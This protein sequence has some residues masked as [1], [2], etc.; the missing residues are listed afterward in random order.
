M[1]D[2]ILTL[3]HGSDHIL[4]KPLFGFGKSDNDYGSGFYTTLSKEKAAEWAAANGTDSAYINTYEIDTVGLNVINLDKYG[5]LSWASEIIYNRG[6][7]GEA[8]ILLGNELVKQYKININD[9]DIVVGYRAD[10]SYSDIVDAFLQNQLNID[11]VQRLF[12]KGELGLQYF[13]KSERAFD[14][15][16]FKGYDELD[17]KK[18]TN[19]P[20][21]QARTEVSKF[22]RARRNQMLLNGY[23]PYGITAREAAAHYYKYNEEYQYYTTNDEKDQNFNQDYDDFD[24]GEER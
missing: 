14:R 7:R 1:N 15:L 5:T 12:Y 10:D 13:I 24:E 21:I 9:A 3:Y 11:E 22:L 8:A 23:Q 2:N 6:A 18:Y 4:P 17:I 20:E 19:Q 16:Q